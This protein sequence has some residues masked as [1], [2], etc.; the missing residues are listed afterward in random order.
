MKQQDDVLVRGRMVSLCQC[1]LT[2]A[3]RRKGIYPLRPDHTGD[4]AIIIDPE[5]DNDGMLSVIMCGKQHHESSST[6]SVLPD[7][8]HPFGRVEKKLADLLDPPEE[9]L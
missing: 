9:K 2:A 7:E 6:F 8:C 1:E 3:D 5:P 4:L